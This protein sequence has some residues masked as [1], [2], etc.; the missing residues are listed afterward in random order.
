M[1]RPWKKYFNFTLTVLLVSLIG[2]SLYVNAQPEIEERVA[3]YVT[4]AAQP[5]EGESSSYELQRAAE[6]FS[7]MV[8]GW[9][10]EPG[11]EL[12]DDLVF[13]G[14]RQEKQNLLF[15]IES[16]SEADGVL[17]LEAIQTKIDTY[18]DASESEYVIALASISD[19]DQVL[20]KA[21]L[22]FGALLL[23]FLTSVAVIFTYDTYHSYRR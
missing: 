16:E 23:S 11:F 20:N 8:L 3:L 21:R 2:T 19:I 6:H 18:N 22:V 13:S 1:K 12:R 7:D 14:R 5:L 9:T 17:L 15:T 10:V 4:L